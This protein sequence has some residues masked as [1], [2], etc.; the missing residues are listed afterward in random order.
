MRRYTSQ[1]EKKNI[2]VIV[3]IVLGPPSSP[4]MD[5]RLLNTSTRTAS[6]ASEQN[7]CT[8]AATVQATPMPRNT[9]TAFD[10]VTFPTDASACL[11]C[12]A[13]TLLANYLDSIT[14]TLRGHPDK[15]ID[16]GQF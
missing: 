13:A 3:L 15:A 10:P 4:P 11:S 9:F 6:I 8:I 5:F 14:T 7:M 2:D 12:I 1:R 16:F